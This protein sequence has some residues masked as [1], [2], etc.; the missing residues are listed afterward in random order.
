MPDDV[1]F[2]TQQVHPW[3]LQRMRFWLGAMIIVPMIPVLVSWGAWYFPNSRTWLLAIPLALLAMVA[4]AWITPCEIYSRKERRNIGRWPLVLF[5]GVLW[6]WAF[7]LCAPASWLRLRGPA[8]E[9]SATVVSKDVQSRRCRQKIRLKDARALLD[10]TLCLRPQEFEALRVQ[11]EVVVKLREG[12][13][14]ALAFSI[15]PGAK[16][17]I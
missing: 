3:R 9:L 15:T 4:S 8:T 17:P 5:L 11:Q 6:A 2:A 13:F 12:Y 1:R 7:G 16:S 14:G 10:G